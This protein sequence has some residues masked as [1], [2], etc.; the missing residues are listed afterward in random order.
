MEHE[1]CLT[2][3]INKGNGKKQRRIPFIC[4]RIIDKHGRESLVEK[5]RS[6]FKIN[7]YYTGKCDLYIVKKSNTLNIR[8]QNLNSVL[9]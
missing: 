4:N 1:R 6:N 7:G 2:E 5:V 8:T 9:L 3:E